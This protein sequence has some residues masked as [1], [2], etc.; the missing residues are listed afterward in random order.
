[1]DPTWVKPADRA[2]AMRA[3]SPLRAFSGLA[4]PPKK[5]AL[6]SSL[7]TKSERSCQ[8]SKSDGWSKEG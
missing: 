1:M 7:V 3:V 6:N 8:L 5:R 4:M 2:L